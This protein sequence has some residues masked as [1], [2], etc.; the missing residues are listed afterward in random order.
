M[1][2]ATSCKPHPESHISVVRAHSNDDV[3]VKPGCFLGNS[4]FMSAES[5]K[6]VLR[7]QHDKSTSEKSYCS[8]LTITHRQPVDVAGEKH[9][10]QI[11]HRVSN[12][13]CCILTTR[14]CARYDNYSPAR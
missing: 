4:H 7:M 12:L 2:Q 10:G 11:C 3:I 8:H 1:V 9:H 13:C 6:V 14:T 5:D